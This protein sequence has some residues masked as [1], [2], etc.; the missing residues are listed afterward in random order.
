MPN[1]THQLSFLFSSPEYTASLHS[2]TNPEAAKEAI[3]EAA[4]SQNRMTNV[5]VFFVAYAAFKY[6]A[7]NNLF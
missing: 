6:G 5:V 7:D 1:L 3:Q 2:G 4:R